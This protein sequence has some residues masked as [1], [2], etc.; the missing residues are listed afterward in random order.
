MTVN[1]THTVLEVVKDP[2]LETWNN[3]N[4]KTNG[5]RL[6]SNKTKTNISNRKT[7]ND[8]HRIQAPDLAHVSSVTA[9]HKKTL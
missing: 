1:K 9:E 8:Y 7:T 5:L 3:A 2:V 6:Q 4:E